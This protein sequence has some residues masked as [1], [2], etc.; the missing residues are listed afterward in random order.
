MIS[1]NIG[2]MT[3][4]YENRDMLLIAAFFKY[5]DKSLKLL[6]LHQYIY[7]G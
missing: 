2:P 7:C 6:N 4:S 1:K 3:E 5:I